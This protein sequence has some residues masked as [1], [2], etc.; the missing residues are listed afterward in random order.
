MS[1]ILVPIFVCVILPV[2][3]VGIIFGASINNDNM[4][5]KILIKAIESNNNIDIEKL[6]ESLKRPEK[7]AR[8]L[9]NLRL[10]RGCIFASLGFVFCILGII[11]SCVGSHFT[12]LEVALPLLFGGSLLAIGVSYLIVYFVTRKQLKDN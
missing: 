4:R 3:I 5:S 2:S 8:Y 7:T 1:E 11:A 6:A 10:L 9:L 12:S